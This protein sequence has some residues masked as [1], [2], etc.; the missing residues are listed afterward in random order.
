[1][2]LLRIRKFTQVHKAF[3]LMVCMLISYSIFTMGQVR[4]TTDKYSDADVFKAVMFLEGPLAVK[5]GSLTDLNVRQIT[6]DKKI[7]QESLDFQAKVIEQLQKGN[8]SYLSKF[9]SDIGSGDFHIV[10]AAIKNAADN[11]VNAASTFTGTTDKAMKAATED[12]KI[13]MS[14]NHLSDKS[15]INEIR[16]AIIKEKGKDKTL[17]VMHWTD[18]ATWLEVVAAVAAVIVLIL[19]LIKVNNNGVNNYLYSKYLSD[20]TLNFKKI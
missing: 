2:I 17:S 1:M 4:T 11:I 5:L 6:N 9:R 16:A 13:F 15:N 10:E 20:V 14:K 7:I 8:S 3:S 12:A 18:I 19:L